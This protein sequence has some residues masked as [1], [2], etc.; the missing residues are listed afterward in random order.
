V[1]TMV[2]G[3]C[4]FTPPFRVTVPGICAALGIP[5]SSAD[6]SW[7]GLMRRYVQPALIAAIEK[8]T[9]LDFA[10]N[11]FEDAITTLVDRFADG[12]GSII[13]IDC[14]YFSADATGLARGDV[15]VDLATRLRLFG[16]PLEFGASWDFRVR[17]GSPDAVLAGIFRTLFSPSATKCPALPAGHEEVRDDIPSRRLTAALAPS[18]ADEAGEVTLSGTFDDGSSDYPAVQVDWGDGSTSTIPAGAS[19]TVSATHSYANDGNYPVTAIVQDAG[20]HAQQLTA[21]VRNVAPTL[22]ALAG[23]PAPSDEHG[24]VT[25]RG[26]FADPGTQ[27]R[28]DVRIDWG[29]GSEPTLHTVATGA[30]SFALEHRYLDDPPEGDAYTVTA[31]LADDDG[32]S[33][34]RTAAVAVANVAP[35]GIRVTPLEVVAAEGEP[36]APDGPVDVTEGAIVTYGIDFDDPGTLDTHSLTVDWGDGDAAQTLEVGAGTRHLELPH[37]FLD[38]GT[39]DV[40]VT[41]TDDDGGQGAATS[42]VQVRNVAPQ[43]TAVLD[44]DSLVE[45]DGVRIEGSIKDPGLLDSHT[46]VIDWG[47]GR[48]DADRYETVAVAAGERTFAATKPYGDDGKFTIAPVV[49]DDDGGEGSAALPL[50]VA[51]AAPAVAI[52]PAG[53]IET[54]GGRTFIARAGSPFELRARATDAGSDDLAVTWTWRDGAATVTDHLSAP[55]AADPDPSPQV[56]PRD[57]V[58]ARRH[59]WPAPCLYEDVAAGVADDDGGGASDRVDLVVTGTAD[60]GE[61]N[62]QREYDPRKAPRNPQATLLCYLRI[63]GQMSAVFGEARALTTRAD[64]Y[65][66]LDPGPAGNTELDKLDRELLGAWLNFAHGALRHGAIAAALRDAE[67]TRLDPAATKKDLQRARQEV[68]GLTE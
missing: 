19:Q 64:A 43:V 6:C 54:P 29:D 2:N 3:T 41:V 30:R 1:T 14:A 4:Y 27:D 61:A 25:M 37:R 53:S 45:G 52:D 40:R 44:D 9:G 12:A 57:L 48:A 24:I 63:A 68:S 13:N 15:D 46:A 59:A 60:S 62:W 58:D 26:A 38:D 33:G 16:H 39:F 22:T 42:P 31:V 23:E 56:A 36:P 32:G 34:T 20:A 50:T 5:S 11:T 47:E 18:V 35:S 17:S 67:A 10:E 7:A 66:V 8:A 21:T 49:T 51:N 28:H 55:P 65:D